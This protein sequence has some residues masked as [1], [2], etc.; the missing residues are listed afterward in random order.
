[1]VKVL[2]S[3][4]NDHAL[5]RALKITIDDSM[6]FLRGEQSVQEKV[7]YLISLLD[8]AS[9]NPNLPPFTRTHLCGLVSTLE[10]LKSVQV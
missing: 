7:S 9:T 1:M 10:S 2:E 6:A 8:E 5:P 3:V 4:M